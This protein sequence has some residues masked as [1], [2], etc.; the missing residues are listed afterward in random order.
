MKKLFLLVIVFL[1][2]GAYLIIQYNNIDIEE[3]EGRRT[4]L[5]RFTDWLFKVGKSTKDV[6]GYAAQQEWLPDNEATN[7]TNETIFVFEKIK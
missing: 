2:I 1:I 4:F 7:E 6:V 5:V 3:E